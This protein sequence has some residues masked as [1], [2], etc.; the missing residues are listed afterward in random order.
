MI[1][2]RSFIAGLLAFLVLPRWLRAVLP[3][4]TPPTIM[5]FI[6]NPNNG[7]DPSQVKVTVGGIE[8][9]GFASEEL[10]LPFLE[11]PCD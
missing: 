3:T 9:E 10:T 11:K 2:R 6:S 5:E 8:C 1:K 4:P 7:F